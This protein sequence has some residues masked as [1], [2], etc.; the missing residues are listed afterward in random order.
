MT[1]ECKNANQYIK[2]LW[3]NVL[4]LLSNYILGGTYEHI[5]IILISLDAIH[6]YILYFP[7][8][9]ANNVIQCVKNG[10]TRILYD[11]C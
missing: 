10:Q 1:Q 5:N 8:H 9:H 6:A 7:T 2:M 4:C 3:M 11:R